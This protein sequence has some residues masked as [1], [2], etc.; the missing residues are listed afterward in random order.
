MLKFVLLS[1]KKYERAELWEKKVSHISKEPHYQQLPFSPLQCVFLHYWQCQLTHQLQRR[2]T[3][4]FL[5]GLTF[6]ALLC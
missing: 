1:C 5:R 3:G 2:T 4:A 6:S